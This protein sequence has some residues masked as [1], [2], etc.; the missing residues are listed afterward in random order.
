MHIDPGWSVE[1]SWS[2][3]VELLG[4]EIYCSADNLSSRA[5]VALD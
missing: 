2:N 4:A 5:L 3:D 1:R